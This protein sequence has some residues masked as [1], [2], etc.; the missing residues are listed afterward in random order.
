[1][2]CSPRIGKRKHKEK[3][4]AYYPQLSINATCV[5]SNEM[6]IV[7][8]MIDVDQVCRI[9]IDSFQIVGNGILNTR[10]TFIKIF[11]RFA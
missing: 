10:I 7:D 3:E 6:G 11:F 2:D 4:E 5:P 9:L 8:G 1:M